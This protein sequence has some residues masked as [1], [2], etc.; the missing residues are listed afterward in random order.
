MRSSAPRSCA[1]RALLAT[2][3]VVATMSCAPRAEAPYDPA[4]PVT[5]QNL[6]AAEPTWPYQV[7]LTR[8]WRPPG[9]AQAL[10][11]GIRGVLIRVETS[12]LLR[13][14]FGG[15]GLYEVPLDATDGLVRANAIRRGEAYKGF[16]NFVFSIGSRLVDPAL[17]A[18]G[19]VNLQEMSKA[20]A[21]LCLFVDPADPAF[22]E[23][24]EA[25]A[26]F[27][28]RP[29]IYTLL[30]PEGSHPD[31]AM[32]QRLREVGWTVPFVFDR[33]AELYRRT[34]VS[35]AKLPRLQVVSP[36]GRVRLE[37]EWAPGVVDRV[38]KALAALG[39]TSIAARATD[40]PLAR[41]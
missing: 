5:A 28:Q 19:G 17:P 16:P 18:I 24:W 10:S 37:T 25:L 36:E 4:E 9:S 2:G 22:V 26:R 38:E 21:F 8:P 34:L 33:L 31:A 40:G 11:A 14:D 39:P 27:G 29:A 15:D 35:D 23:M 1:L 13:V 6:L 20:D 7:V 32:R 3:I 12:G 41:P 30:F